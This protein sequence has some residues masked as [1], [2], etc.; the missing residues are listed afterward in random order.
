MLKCVEAAIIFSGHLQPI[1]TIFIGIAAVFISIKTFRN[2][3]KAREHTE[4]IT[5]NSYKRDGI[6]LVSTMVSDQEEILK[7][8]RELTNSILFE[9]YENSDHLEILDKQGELI[10]SKHLNMYTE[11]I[12]SYENLLT[13]IRESD[14]IT[15]ILDHIFNLEYQRLKNKSNC[16][17]LIEEYKLNIKV[18]LEKN[19]ILN[20][21]RTLEKEQAKSSKENQ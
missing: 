3:H 9:E 17:S 5:L 6:V 10:L 20:E 1:I 13:E 16:E 14:S 18:H 7:N 8:V 12:S 15:E 21:I 19:S 2:A 11:L 4:Y